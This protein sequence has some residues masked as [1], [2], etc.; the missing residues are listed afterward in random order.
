V[1]STGFSFDSIDADVTISDGVARTDD[2]RMN[3]VSAEVTMKG[4]V[5]LVTETQD[6]EVHVKPELSSAAA[7][8]GAAVINP[9]VGVATL[10]V[11][12][13]LGDPVEEAASRDY[14]VS[15]TW[16]DPQVERIERTSAAATKPNAP[17]R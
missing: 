1:F 8:A 2:L 4:A 11:Q 13:A 5:N 10:L 7:V 6:L 15:G 17:G 16:A 14:R 3:G 9:L 12:K